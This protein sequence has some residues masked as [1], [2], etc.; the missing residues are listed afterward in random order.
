MGGWG[1]VGGR[2]ANEVRVRYGEGRRR[3][4]G[5]WENRFFKDLFGVPR[6]RFYVPLL[7]LLRRLET[8]LIRSKTLL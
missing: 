3:A 8:L 1:W 6:R 2:K 7:L 5:G 4:Q